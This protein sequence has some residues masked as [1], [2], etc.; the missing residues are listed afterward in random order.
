MIYYVSPSGNDSNPGT[1]EQPWQNLR[2][3]ESRIDEGDTVLLLPGTYVGQWLKID[4][5]G[6]TWAAA[7]DT[8]RPV[9]SGGY[10]RELLNAQGKLSKPPT[11]FENGGIYK[12]WWWIDAPNVTAEGLLFRDI[13]GRALMVTAG[14]AAV[15]N[16]DF[17]WTYAEAINVAPTTVIR[18]IRIVNCDA[19]YTSVMEL[20]PSLAESMPY[21]PDPNTGAIRVSLDDQQRPAARIFDAKNIT[22][23]TGPL[24]DKQAGQAV[25]RGLDE[26]RHV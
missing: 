5:P 18:N 1:A 22:G 15:L 9:I 23:L 8:D 26:Q 25:R 3:A 17:N 16:C 20:D 7:D 6:T 10:G 14:D 13:P 12:N 4:T 24:L 19:S 21:R 11:E 2:A